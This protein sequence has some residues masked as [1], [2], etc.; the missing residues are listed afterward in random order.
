MHLAFQKVNKK[1]LWG[2]YIDWDNR[3][4]FP[5]YGQLKLDNVA[6]WGSW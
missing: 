6:K 5:L 3:H 1:I 2:R 4:F